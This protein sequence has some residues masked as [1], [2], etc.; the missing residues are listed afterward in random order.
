MSTWGWP[1]TIAFL[2]GLTVSLLA[3]K[4]DRNP[5]G[6]NWYLKFLARHPDFKTQWA[7]LLDQSRH[8]A[9][10]YKT[11]NE[12]FTLYHNTCVT[13]GISPHDQ[14][15]MDEKGFAKGVIDNVK[16]II[17]VKER[18]DIFMT[19]PGNREWVSIIEC[20]NSSSYKLPPFIIFPGQRIQQSWI[21]SDIDPRTVIHVSSNGWTD[22]DIAVEWIKHFDY[23]TRSNTHGQ[24][25][26]LILDGHLSHTSYE[27]IQYCEDQKIVPLCLP[28]HA[29]HILQPLDV[30]VFGPLA[31]AYK[32]RVREHSLFGAERITNDEFLSHYQHAREKAISIQNISS[33]WR[34]TGLIPYN[35]API[36]QKFRPKTPPQASLIDENGRRIEITINEP[37]LA[38][39]VN[40]LVA[41]IIETQ[42]H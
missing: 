4:G 24:Y 5:L 29:T 35:P 1:M 40:E 12:W 2:E 13:Y 41:Q 27:F 22:R 14:Y 9:T 19:Q 30:G 42:I 28:P 7:R 23:Y 38:H 33:S 20:I 11:L 26:L 31:K 6:H 3:S 18:G 10:D 16:V 25:R 32:S 36:L 34:A 37:T 17:S 8:D 39:K 15:N 21:P